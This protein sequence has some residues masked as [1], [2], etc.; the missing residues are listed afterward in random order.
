MNA[1]G[2]YSLNSSFNERPDLLAKREAM[3]LMMNPSDAAHKGLRNQQEVIAFNEGGE[4]TF[5]LQITVKV[6]V[7]VVVAEGIFWI[8]LGP[9]DRSVN[10][11]TSQ[12]LTDRMAGSTFY[13]TKV[14]IRGK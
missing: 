4:V 13:D 6:P 9:G 14:D 7:G 8:Q 1:P 2:L 10:A 3:Y 5:I 11:L 12:R